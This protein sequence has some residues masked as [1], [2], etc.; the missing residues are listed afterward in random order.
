[1]TVSWSK[2]PDFTADPERKAAVQEATTRDKEHYLR[3]GLTEIECRACHARV[4]V[5]KYSPHHTSV[6]WTSAARDN[7]PEFKAIRAEGGNPAMLPTCPRMSAS[8]D[9]GVSEGIIPKESPDVDPD[10]YY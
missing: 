10:G 7:C 2:A 1:M 4:M 6:Q 8:I 3:G 9:H 5:K